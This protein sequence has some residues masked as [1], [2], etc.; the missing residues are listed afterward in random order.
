MFHAFTM[1]FGKR[2]DST[3]NKHNGI[4]GTSTTSPRPPTPREV[5]V[6]LLFSSQDECRPLLLILGPDKLRHKTELKTGS[7]AVREH[8]F[9]VCVSALSRRL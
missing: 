8:L 7:G 5:E 3:L 9:D 1:S 4:S 2:A 6:F